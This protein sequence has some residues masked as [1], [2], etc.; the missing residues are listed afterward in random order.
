MS[1][2]QSGW[3]AIPI[4]GDLFPAG[5]PNAALVGDRPPLPPVWD[6]IPVW[7][8]IYPTGDGKPIYDMTANAAAA[9]YVASA[10]AT[11]AVRAVFPPSE[12]DG[13]GSGMSWQTIA[14]IALGAV[15]IV[16]M[17]ERR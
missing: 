14:L 2:I 9:K 13:S 8:D 12:D 5:G 1:V 16:G 15:V 7:G 11:A 10:G 4:W 17:L 3:N 6:S